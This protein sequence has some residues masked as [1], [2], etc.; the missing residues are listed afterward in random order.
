MSPNLHGLRTAYQSLWCT[1]N[2]YSPVEFSP[3]MQST[4]NI[5][6]ASSG[7][8]TQKRNLSWQCLTSSMAPSNF[9]K[10]RPFK[11][12][13]IYINKTFK[14]FIKSSWRHSFRFAISFGHSQNPASG[15]EHANPKAP[16]GL[17]VWLILWNNVRSK[18]PHFYFS[19][20]NSLAPGRN[21]SNFTSAFFQ[22]HFT[23][24]YQC[25]TFPIDRGPDLGK[26]WVGLGKLSNLVARQVYGNLM[27]F[28]LWQHYWSIG[29]YCWSMVNYLN[30]R[31][32]VYDFCKH[33]FAH[34]DILSM[35][36]AF[37]PK[38]VSDE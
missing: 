10:I 25:A 38:L 5:I 12:K 34:C 28:T 20:F 13:C 14:T 18:D 23:N 35:C 22:T 1:V 21:G 29:I 15:G 36:W 33:Y 19:C 30:P 4:K 37:L 24:W 27:C 16:A 9:L 32:V 26:N 2:D 31:P 7:N 17:P 8:E 11:E 6:G 3:R